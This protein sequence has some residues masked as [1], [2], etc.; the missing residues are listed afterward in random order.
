MQDNPKQ[1]KDIQPKNPTTD[2]DTKRRSF[3]FATKMA[4]AMNWLANIPDKIAIFADVRVAIP[5]SGFRNTVPR[6]RILV[7]IAIGNR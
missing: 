4:P 7:D 1:H 2:S 5:K 3:A 6:T